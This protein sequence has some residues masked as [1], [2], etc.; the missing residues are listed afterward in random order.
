MEC[1]DVSARLDRA[2]ARL[3]E[4]DSHLLENDLS[5]RCIAARLALYLQ[6]EFPEDGISVDVEYNRL[7]ERVKRLRLPDEC[8]RRRNRDVDA[9][10]LRH[11]RPLPRGRWAE[12][13]RGRT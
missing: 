12:H 5:E 10:A 1:D 9:A 7:G 6:A 2:L 4:R 13:P 8:V 11:H 3:Q